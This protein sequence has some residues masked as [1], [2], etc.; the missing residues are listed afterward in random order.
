LSPG[1]RV[2]EAHMDIKKSQVELRPLSISALVA[3]LLG[4]A[5]YWWVPMGM[6]WSRMGAWVR[7]L[8][9]LT[10]AIT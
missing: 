6:M 8:D 2:E 1:Y 7:R 10:P 9:T 4:F 5:F 3:A